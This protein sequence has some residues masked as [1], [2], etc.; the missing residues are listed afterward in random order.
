MNNKINLVNGNIIT[1]DDS[2]PIA[3][4]ISLENG[5][6][7]GI[8]AIDHNHKSINLQGATVIPGFTDSH[9]HLTN[10]G[11]QL[12]TIQ[13]KN[14]KSAN[15]VAET[16]LKKKSINELKDILKEMDLKVSGN[17]SKLIMRIID[18]K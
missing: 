3:D 4:T 2:C 11:K 7:A 8:N 6:I 1:L 10:L 18:N 12:D 13:L 14:C 16:V 5:K 9:F 15:E 17:K